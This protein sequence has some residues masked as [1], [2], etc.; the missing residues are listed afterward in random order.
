MSSARSPGVRP[1][2]G[3]H[4]ARPR[5][6]PVDA[7]G[8]KK[9]LPAVRRQ[10]RREED[11]DEETRDQ[12]TRGGPR[13]DDGKAAKVDFHGPQTRCAGIVLRTF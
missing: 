5:Q 1:V 4:W 2:D 6:I 3:R 8:S 9:W 13:Q 12:E 11:E 10:S 7:P